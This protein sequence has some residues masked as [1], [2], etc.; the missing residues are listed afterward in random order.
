MSSLQL[1]ADEL[2]AGSQLTFEVAIPAN[3]LSPSLNGAGA[4]DEDRVV[5][6][7]PLTLTDLQKIARAA[8]ENDALIAALMVQQSLVDPQMSVA[9]VV[10]LHAGLVQFLLE[11]VNQISGLS[12]SAETLST[13]VT[14]P[15]AK[16]AF[17]LAREFGWTPQEVNQLTLGQMLLHLKMLEGSGG[18]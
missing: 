2:L 13:T 11:R 4:A 6:L 5:Q 8:K 17:I 12:L 9:Q 1:T 16:A 7:R 3:I 15:L 14:A 18:Q 10:A